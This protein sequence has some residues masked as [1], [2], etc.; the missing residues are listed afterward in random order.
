MAIQQAMDFNP[1]PREE[2]DSP[3]ELPL[4]VDSISI[5]ALVKR[6][7]TAYHH[8]GN[9]CCY[10]NPRPREEGDLF[11]CSLSRSKLHFNP[12]PREEGDSFHCLYYKVPVYFNPRPREEGDLRL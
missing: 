12:R 7:T 8:I 9:F 4:Y 6:A 10:F 1:R 5:H 2:G 11:I 3:E